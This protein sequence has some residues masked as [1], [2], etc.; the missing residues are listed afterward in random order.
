MNVEPVKIAVEDQRR[1]AGLAFVEL[2]EALERERIAV[3][4]ARDPQGVCSQ[5]V[6]FLK[7]CRVVAIRHR[8]GPARGPTMH[9]GRRR[10]R[11]PARRCS[12]SSGRALRWGCRRDHG[13]SGRRAEGAFYWKKTK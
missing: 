1:A 11:S 4:A 7:N 5:T 12:R 10:R 9:A 8:A 13:R 3:Q 6:L 2:D